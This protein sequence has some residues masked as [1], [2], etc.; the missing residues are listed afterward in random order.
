M[1]FC[2][3]K[4]TVG[5]EVGTII[6]QMMSAA[7]EMAVPQSQLIYFSILSFYNVFLLGTVFFTFLFTYLSL[8]PFFFLREVVSGEKLHFTLH[9]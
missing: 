2:F 5:V 9:A 1:Y 3:S 8:V 4:S 7:A 6:S